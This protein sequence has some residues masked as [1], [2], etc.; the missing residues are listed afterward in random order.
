MKSRD[1]L[2]SFSYDMEWRLPKINQRV[3]YLDEKEN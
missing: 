2:S 1:V 3:R